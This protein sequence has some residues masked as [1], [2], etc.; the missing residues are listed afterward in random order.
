MVN[1][2]SKPSSTA[3]RRRSVAV[4]VLVGCTVAFSCAAAAL[5]RPDQGRPTGAA[6]HG[7]AGQT[8]GGES[9]KQG[10]VGA[11]AGTPVDR[12]QSSGSREEMSAEPHESMVPGGLEQQGP[13]RGQ[14][15]G[16]E[17]HSGDH[18]PQAP[19]GSGS[20]GSAAEEH[21]AQKHE[22][23]DRSGGQAPPAESGA[24]AN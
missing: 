21:H 15:K 4:A 23:S 20:Q 18:E 9:T 5:A 17:Q 14:H 13:A 6:D 7:A 3:A 24:P 8:P 10:Q 22:R 11:R 19:A 2:P 12:R 16:A 1:Y